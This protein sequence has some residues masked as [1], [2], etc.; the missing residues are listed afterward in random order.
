MHNSKN[1]D[2]RFLLRIRVSGAELALSGWSLR[3]ECPARD[4]HGYPLAERLATD[5]TRVQFA[6]LSPAQI[7]ALRGRQWILAAALALGHGHGLRS[8]SREVMG[9][10]TKVSIAVA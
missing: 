5:T 2:K 9:S 6:P 4:I 3:G 1:L 10:L 7:E 8:V